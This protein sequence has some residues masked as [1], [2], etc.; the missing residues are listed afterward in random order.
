MSLSK[1][2]LS[3]AALCAIGGMSLGIRMGIAQD[4]TLA[5][6]HAHLNLLGWVTMALYGLWHRTGDRVAGALAWTQ[7]VLGAL[8]AVL[9]AGGLGI[10]LQTG[11]S[12]VLPVIIAGSL[13]AFAGMFLFF[14]LVVTEP[15]RDARGV[16]KTTGR[17]LTA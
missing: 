9:M 6:A 17:P 11:N 5:P 16:S 15:A 7:S 13:C 10:E 3:I 4:F 2:C 1:F 14:V 8:G 12:A